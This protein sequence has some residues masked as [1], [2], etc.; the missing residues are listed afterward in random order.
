VSQ[1]DVVITLKTGEVVKGWMWE[2]KP[3]DGFFTVVDRVTGPPP[4]VIRF[5]DC[6][7]AFDRDTNLLA[8]AKHELT[9]VNIEPRDVYFIT[10]TCE[11]GRRTRAS[12]MM[13][14]W[15][16]RPTVSFE[17]MEFMVT[18]SKGPGQIKN[19]KYP[20][21]PEIQKWAESGIG[22]GRAVLMMRFFA[23]LEAR[24]TTAANEAKVARERI[25][26]LYAASK[27]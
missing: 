22:E 15:A 26:A 13:H 14:N 4:I 6:A 16:K 2:W 23:M 12:A 8:Q 21:W 27:K 10:L 18:T 1:T 25:G 20:F 11:C 3:V 5:D 17:D 7:S 24:M 19:N 9:L